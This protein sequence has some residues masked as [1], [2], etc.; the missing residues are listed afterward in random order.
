MGESKR[1]HATPATYGDRR[2]GKMFKISNERRKGVSVRV[3]IQTKKSP[4]G[5]L[6]KVVP[7]MMMKV[8]MIVG[9]ILCEVKAVTK[10]FTV[11]VPGSPGRAVR[12]L[13]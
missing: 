7:N 6:T 8:L 12:T 4:I 5:Q 13:P 3:V 9:K 10:L 2:N 1:L 11:N